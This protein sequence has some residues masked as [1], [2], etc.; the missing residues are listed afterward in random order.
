MT[1]KAVLFD[2]DGTLVD[3]VPQLTS[4]VN[5]LMCEMGLA[6][7]TRDEVAAMVGKGVPVL[8]ERIALAR[9]LTREPEALARMQSNYTRAMKATDV[10]L[11]AF[12]PGVIEALGAL[13]EA[14]IKPVLVTNKMRLM[15]EDFLDKTGTAHLFDAVVAAG[16]TPRAKPAPDMVEL[17]CRKAGA[18]PEEAV[19]IGD[20]A[21]DALAAAAAGVRI[22]LV[23]TG[24]NEGVPID[25]WA[26]QNGFGEVLDDTA[27]ACRALLAENAR[28]S[29]RGGRCVCGNAA[30]SQS[31]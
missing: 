1:L 20:S 30:P 6:A 14:G 22:I 5:A 15:T 7:F 24:Y 29:L 2:L 8:I 10:R 16:D 25:Q 4:G 28:I 26:H 3:S 27:Q 12:F 19:M 18:L 23:R 31:D 21:N 13:R 9:G 17:A 11:A